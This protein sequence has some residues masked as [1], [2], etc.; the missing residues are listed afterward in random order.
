[1]EIIRKVGIAIALVGLA[2]SIGTLYALS[3]STQIEI[4]TAA[5]I[6]VGYIQNNVAYNKNG[7]LLGR[8]NNQ[9]NT[10]TD[11]AGNVV[12]RGNILPA[13]IWESNCED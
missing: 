6:K 2:I 13:L 9:N 11:K 10:T 8:Y 12:A 4:R 7:I 1:M 3:H 5:D